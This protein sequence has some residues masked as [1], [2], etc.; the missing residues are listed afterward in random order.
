[1]LNGE[2]IRRGAPLFSVTDLERALETL[3]V[4][5]STP[6]RIYSHNRLRLSLIN[7]HRE[8]LFGGAFGIGDS[9]RHEGKREG[10]GGEWVQQPLTQLRTLFGTTPII[11]SLGRSSVTQNSD[12][13]LRLPDFLGSV[14]WENNAPWHDKQIPESFCEQPRLPMCNFHC[15][16]RKPNIY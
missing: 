12:T 16:P 10:R 3:I 13:A 11:S 5:P 14:Y 4:T 8:F 6:R 15:R 7:A 1:M 2:D 9:G